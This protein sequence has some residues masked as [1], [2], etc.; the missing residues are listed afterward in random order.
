MAVYGGPEVVKDGLVF[1]LDLSNDKTNIISNQT[2]NILVDPGTWTEGSGGVEGYTVNGGN[3]EQN[4]LLVVNDDPWGRTS[5]TWRT[6]PDSVPGPDGGW[7]TVYASID[8]N[9]TYRWSVWVRRYTTGIGGTFY[10]GMNPAPIRNDTNLVQGNPYFTYPAISLLEHNKWYLVVA[11]C[12]YQNYS[13]GRHPESGWYKDG[14]KI[15]DMH[16]GNLGTQDVRWNTNTTVAMHRTYHFYTTNTASGLEF[17]YPRIDKCDGT[18]PS[19]EKLINV[20]DSPGFRSSFNKKA[21]KVRN[22]VSLSTDNDIF[23]YFSFDGVDD[24]I[25]LPNDLGYTDS[26]SAFAWFKPSGSPSGGYHIIFGGQELEI[27]IP[28]SG[29]LRTGLYTNSRFVSNHGS[30]LLDG[31]WHQVGFTFA[32]GVKTSY[33]DGVSVGTQN[34]TGT[35]T[36]SFANRTM[37]RYGNSSTY[38]LNGRIALAKIYNNSLSS[39][40]VKKNYIAL[41]GRFGS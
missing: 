39:E 34:V 18:E 27:S 37:G 35:L 41:R 30:G 33:I 29:E 28:T 40:E 31:N 10:F 13:G 24:Y 3:E 22:S 4:R 25:E 14:V 15:A 8:R 36:S 26:V 21:I 20:G 32:N 7:N 2:S 6:V 11:H 19:I 17:A 16:Y 12:F 23:K 38:Y 9:Y 1:N 5:V